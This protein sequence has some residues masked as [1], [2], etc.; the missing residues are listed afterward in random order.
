MQK[1][2]N[3]VGIPGD[4]WLKAKMF[5][6]ELKNA[7]H[8]SETKMVTFVM[9][10]GS[11]MNASLKAMKACKPQ[12]PPPFNCVLV[13]VRGHKLHLSLQFTCASKEKR[14]EEVECI[15]HF[16]LLHSCKHLQIF[17]HQPR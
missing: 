8:V 9:N 3:V 16:C 14:L 11:K 7:G 5:D 12:S 2:N 1:V 4:V 17:T 6:V 13:W 10:Q 15:T